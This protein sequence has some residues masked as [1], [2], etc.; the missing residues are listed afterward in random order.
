[1]VE[2]YVYD[3]DKPILRASYPTRESMEN[4]DGTQKFQRLILTEKGARAMIERLTEQREA[5]LRV[6]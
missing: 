5:T 3:G 6:G 2:M 4:S 1:M